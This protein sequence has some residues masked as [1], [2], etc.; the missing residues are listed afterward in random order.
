MS[1]KLEITRRD[2]LNGV[3]LSLAAGTSLS[4]L[5]AL[6]GTPSAA[7]YYPPLLTGLRGSHAGSWEV[8]HSVA[9]A[10]AS[11]EFPQEQTDPTYELVVV[12][13]GIS[14]LAAAHFHAKQAGEDERILVIDNH[15]D[16]GG[17]AKRNEFNV[18]GRHLIA[19]GGSQ[20]M[21]SPG[22]YSRVAK[23][24]LDDVGI[25]TARF[26]DYFDRG[27]NQ[28]HG[29]EPVIY[30]SKAAYGKDA[31]LQNAMG[32][33]QKDA[34][35]KLARQIIAD[36]PLSAESRASL[37]DL[38]VREQDYLAGMSRGEKRALLASIS[39]SDYLRKH[40]GVTE[41][42]VTL[43][44]DTIRGY[45]GV[46]WDSLSALEAYR[47]E[48]PATGKL[49]VEIDKEGLWSS[50]EP[51]IFHFPDGNAGIA[52]ALVRRLLPAA[53]P[54]STMEDLVA[55]RVDY[56]L[57]DQA[58]ERVR[59][60]LNST[61]VNVRHTPDQSGVDVVYVRDG[62]TERVRARHVVLACYNRIIP[63]IFPE[64]PSRQRQAMEYAE[65][66]PLV[67]INIAV[68]NWQAFA[69]LGSYGVYVP[70]PELMH[71]FGL[72]FPVSIGDY[73]YTSN[74]DQATVLH[75][76]FIPTFPDQGLSRK[77][78]A[79]LG[80]RK[81]LGMSFDDYESAILRQLEGALGSA[82]FDAGRDIAAITVNRWPHGYAYEYEELDD[83]P[84]FDRTHGPHVTGR[85]RIGRV[86][87]ANSDSEA[88]AYADGAID[89]ADRAVR[90]QLSV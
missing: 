71:S 61:A 52:R 20:S 68:R 59:I 81:L 47:T 9:L 33:Y 39:Y 23:G 37:H 7:S 2:F 50:G 67:Y 22:M 88:Y 57:L 34:D 6:A 75:G 35:P 12:G 43:M 55:T 58:S 25:E 56:S 13:G 70:Q 15:D 66:T 84:E 63:Y 21:E 40:V 60:R 80:R 16:F 8:A 41:E 3:A 5:E 24:L 28:D 64:L 77:E 48:Q 73:R 1:D 10:G 90:E 54:G 11:Y 46:G 65:K 87:I 76:T 49:G 36:Y 79:L 32:D 27:F 17:H 83:P 51:Y 89:A 86:S 85:A 19:Y 30:F 72:D 45:W 44:R 4:P 74:P 29:L 14:G 38:L 42:V 69:N 62:K 26:Y 78:Q 53:L 82:G 18:D 31:T